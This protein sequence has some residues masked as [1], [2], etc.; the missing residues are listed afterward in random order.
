[1]GEGEKGT[2][3]ASLL[4]QIGPFLVK[5]QKRLPAGVASDFHSQPWK[6]STDTRAKRFGGGLFGGKAGGEGDGGSSLG[7]GV[8]YF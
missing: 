3:Y 7:T 1:M 6:R 2:G 8:L 4:S 5:K